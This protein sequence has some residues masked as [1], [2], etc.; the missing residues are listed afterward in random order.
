ME[1]KV[2]YLRMLWALALAYLYMYYENIPYLL[3]GGEM[4]NGRNG[5]KRE[6]EGGGREVGLCNIRCRQVGFTISMTFY[7]IVYV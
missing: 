6:W 7:E 3:K 4:R 2:P 1:A 5:R